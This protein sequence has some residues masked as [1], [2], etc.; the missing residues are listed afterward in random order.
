MCFISFTNKREDLEVQRHYK[1]QNN[2]GC[3]CNGGCT[4]P[5]P[6]K[7]HTIISRNT[8][9]SESTLIKQHSCPTKIC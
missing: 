7:C 6:I 8:R 2:A 3:G 4:I 5:F 1:I 9:T